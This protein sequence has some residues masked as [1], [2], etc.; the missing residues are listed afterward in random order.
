MP[1]PPVLLVHGIWDSSSRLQPLRDGLMARGISCVHALDLVPN[2]GRAS[3]SELGR[4]VAQEAEALSARESVPHIDIV[5]FSMGALV[6]RW[7]I[8]R[9]GGKARIRRFVSISGPH[10][11]TLTAYAL[12]R[13]G[14]RDMR[15][16]SALLRDL[17]SDADPF[18]SAEVHCVLTPFDLMIVPSRSGVL[19]EARSTTSFPVAMHRFMI[20]DARVLDHVAGLLRA[21]SS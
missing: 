19:A 7:Y 17:E 2:D 14:V 3:I 20:T 4:F 1:T 12:P 21:P 8:Q 15:P 13:R 10:H 5:G 11:G 16:R 6:S 9:G 18:G